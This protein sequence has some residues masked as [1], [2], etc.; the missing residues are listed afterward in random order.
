[1]P[2]PVTVR[3]VEV[4]VDQPLALA[5]DQVP[6]P[7]ST[8]LVLVLLEPTN[9]VTVT[10]YEAAENV[11]LVIERLVAGIVNASCNVTV[12]EGE[13]MSNVPVKSLPALVIV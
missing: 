9:P 11:P 7:I 13:F 2:V 1:M 5:I 12:P 8:V 6:D 3:L 10:L 4:E